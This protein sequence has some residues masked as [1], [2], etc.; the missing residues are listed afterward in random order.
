LSLR[1]F[2]CLGI[3]KDFFFHITQIFSETSESIEVVHFKVF[4]LEK[5]LQIKQIVY[6]VK[7]RPLHW[8]LTEKTFLLEFFFDLWL[9]QKIEPIHRFL[10]LA[11]DF[12]IF[13]SVFFTLLFLGDKFLLESNRLT[14]HEVSYLFVEVEIEH[15]LRVFSLK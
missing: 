6:H 2:L 4:A 11:L 13:V 7:I 12:G 15:C 9:V 1:R 8:D 10:R 14:D 3:W 5:P